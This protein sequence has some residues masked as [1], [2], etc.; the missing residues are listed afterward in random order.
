MKL[1]VLL[2]LAFL[3]QPAVVAAQNDRLD[4]HR[5]RLS[6]LTA[7]DFAEDISIRDDDLEIIATIDTSEGYRVRGGFFSTERTDN[8]LR[9][10]INKQTGETHYLLYQ[11][12]TYTS[13]PQRWRWYERANYQS[14]NGLSTA[15]LESVTREVV[16][17]VSRDLCVF[18]EDFVLRLTEEAVRWIA[19]HE[20][21]EFWRF[22]FVA[23]DG[24]DWDDILAPAEAAGLLIAVDNYRSAR[25]LE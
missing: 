5:E 1:L 7:E 2:S 14:P 18:R 3:L 25:A 9:S 10:T 23:N 22:R 19:N 17:C 20:P 6:R 13:L 24:E 11:T 8:F 15:R 16:S 21:G 4:R 12:I